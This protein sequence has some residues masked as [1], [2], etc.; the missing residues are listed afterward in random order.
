MNNQETLSCHSRII[1]SHLCAAAVAAASMANC[2]IVLSSRY[3]CSHLVIS[4][5]RA[6]ICSSFSRSCCWNVVKLLSE[7]VRWAGWFWDC[8]KKDT[9]MRLI[10]IFMKWVK[11]DRT[12]P[13]LYV[14]YQ[15]RQWCMSLK[16]AVATHFF[17]VPALVTI[18]QLTMTKV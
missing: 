3:F 4:A 12:C 2:L 1:S 16:Q 14:D 8:E 9:N 13:E 17:C 15:H 18:P 11:H 5:S 6:R 7:A 10:E